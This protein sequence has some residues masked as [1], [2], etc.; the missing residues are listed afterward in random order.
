MKKKEKRLKIWGLIEVAVQESIQRTLF[1]FL[2]T[3]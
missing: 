1:Q 3:L 2:S